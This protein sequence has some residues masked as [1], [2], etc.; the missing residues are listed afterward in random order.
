M[1]PA[2][3]RRASST[4]LGP[5]NRLHAGAVCTHLVGFLEEGELSSC[6]GFE[7]RIRVLVRV[8]CLSKLPECLLDVIIR[9]ISRHVQNGIERSVIITAAACFHART[10]IGYLFDSVAPFGVSPLKASS[11][12]RGNPPDH[13]PCEAPSKSLQGTIRFTYSAL[14]MQH[15]PHSCHS[16]LHVQIEWR[17]MPGQNCSHLREESAMLRCTS[18]L[19]SPVVP[20]GA[21]T[22]YKSQVHRWAA[23]PR[24]GQF[25]GPMHGERL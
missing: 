12:S 19:Y 16:I 14:N 8:V 4:T 21:T 15:G 2:R 11:A 5:K 1:W 6:V 7:G 3:A 25:R 17:H 24:G 20:G 10:P 9:G 18:L 13:R 22:T 23:C